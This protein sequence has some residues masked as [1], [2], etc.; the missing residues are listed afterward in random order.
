MTS[1]IF[2]SRFKP[3]IGN[4]INPDMVLGPEIITNN[5]FDA[6]TDW[7]DAR[8]TA[9][10][11]VASNELVVTADS[12]STFGAATVLSGMVIGDDYEFKAASTADN[13][14]MTMLLRIG[15]TQSLS[16]SDILQESGSTS[17]SIDG[18]F[19][20]TAVIMYAGVIGFGHNAADTIELASGI[21]VK[22][23]L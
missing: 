5:T 14:S 12:G 21:S 9:S 23:R 4:M 20:A 16:V 22:K 17:I 6:T 10:L 3:M 11:S 1:P 15:L 2:K 8:G 13:A 18:V 19:T 7:L